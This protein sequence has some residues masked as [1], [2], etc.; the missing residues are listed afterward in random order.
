[1]LA[2][3]KQIKISSAGSRK[4]ILWPCQT[5][6]WSEFVAKV[7]IPNRGDETYAEYL[8]FPK[9]RQDAL[10]D[11]GGFVGATLHEDRR[12]AKN[13]ASRDLA[14]LDLDHIPAGHTLDV[15]RRVDGLGCA[16]TIYS[17]RKHSSAF[18]RLRVCIPFDRPV[19]SD[20]Y[21]AV[22][23]KLG[24]LIGIDLCDATTFEAHRL[25]YWPSCS[26]DGE[27]VH[28]Y[29]DKPFVSADGLLGMY[30]NWKDVTS[31]PRVPGDDAAFER[32]FR[33]RRQEDPT[34]KHGV[35]GAF[36]RTYNIYEAMEEYIPTEYEAV[37]GSDDR[38]TYLAGSTSGGA[39]VYDNGTFL[40]SHHSTD[41]CCDDLVNSFD[42]VR[43][44]LFGEL[45]NSALENTPSN[46][47]PS[48]V[49]MKVRA[50]QDPNVIETINNE[51]D[52]AVREQFG[53]AHAEGED[54]EDGGISWRTKL[55]I[56]DGKVL[57]TFQNVKIALQNDPLLKGRVKLNLFNT[58]LTGYAPLPWGRRPGEE[59][60]FRWSDYDDAGLRGYLE[61]SLGFRN[62]DIIKDAFDSVADESAFNPITDYLK[63]QTWDGVPRLDTL[64]IDYFG[65]EDC[66]YTRRVTRKSI[67]A[68]VARA[69]VPGIKF[70]TMTI[71]SGDTGIGKSTFFDK[72]AGQY[73]S[74]SVY[75]M[76]GK[77]AAELIQ[78]AW[79][80]EIGELD[81]YNKSGLN[82]VLAYL[83]KRDDQY[84][85]SYG[86][87]VS[88]HPRNC[89]FYGTTNETEFLRAHVG[90]R[91]FWTVVAGRQAPTKSV[92][93]D[94]ARER[95]QIWAEAVHNWNAGE[96]IYLSKD[97]ENEAIIRREAHTI[98]D[99]NEGMIRAFLDLTLP[100]GWYAAD[101]SMRM[102]YRPTAEDGDC[103]PR[104]KVCVAEI[105]RE[106][107]RMPS[108]I[109]P[110]RESIRINAIL[111]RIE[112]WTPGLDKTT[113]GKDYGE[114]RYFKRSSGEVRG[115]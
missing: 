45:D 23:R 25:M 99:P 26:S 61:A 86:K 11:V 59:G 89:V 67:V 32:C 104:K 93:N 83:A 96:T 6:Y 112:G 98:Y 29:G 90:N 1:M 60:A 105:W 71:V 19:T 91:R 81:A 17:T 109:I 24:E 48:Y 88:K 49:A 63:A 74:D 37:D 84:R 38:L 3:D 34:A 53:Y 41:P 94:L 30:T 9:P 5:L 57:K 68:A 20:E 46:R 73:F 10:K 78:E 43:R 44:H 102:A 8:G 85:A 80:V 27:F 36:C 33:A 77:E 14:T 108:S 40:Y 54:I 79:I 2:N 113:F 100:K 15:V 101:M 92:F 76:E 56:N 51:R 16:Y 7:A 42:L 21:G 18:P 62:K 97:E 82:N 114:Q 28:H 66:P 50:L 72:L 110:R 55:A 13:V 4:A 106:C 75:T 47:V 31:W 115:S 35:V 39:V 22:T 103:T 70:D 12:K 69:F 58:E 95:D 107:L 111:R 87:H 64:F 52:A 65:A